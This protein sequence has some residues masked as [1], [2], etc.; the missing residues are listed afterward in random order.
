MP[1]CC[2]AY[3]YATCKEDTTGLGCSNAFLHLRLLDYF[4]FYKLNLVKHQ[5][6]Q[7]ISLQVTYEHNIAIIVFS[8]SLKVEIQSLPMRVTGAVL[9]KFLGV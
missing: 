9:L 6:T 4:I 3:T 5:T 8:A 7:T 1:K 2:S